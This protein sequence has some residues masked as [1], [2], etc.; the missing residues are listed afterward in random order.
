MD[1]SGYPDGL[2]G[3]E[4]P[5]KAQILNVA[6]VFNALTTDRPYRK[7]FE[8][9]KAFEIMSQMPLNQDLV[10]I[11]RTHYKIKSN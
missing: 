11:L 6:D 5:F 2:K 8:E 9:N 10:N 3:N 4:I 1:G 7:G